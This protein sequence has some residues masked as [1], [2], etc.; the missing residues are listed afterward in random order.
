MVNVK[1]IFVA[2]GFHKISHRLTE[3]SPCGPPP[4]THTDVQNVERKGMG[5]L[6]PFTYGTPDDVNVSDY[7]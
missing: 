4:P 6:S 7:C 2:K 3:H 5:N 1:K